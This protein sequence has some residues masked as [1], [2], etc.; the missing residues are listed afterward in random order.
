MVLRKSE[1]LIKIFRHHPLPFVLH[2]FILF[3]LL[4]P[5]YI[6]LTVLVGSINHLTLI[7]LKS[8]LVALTMLLVIYHSFIFWLDKIIITNQRVINIDWKSLFHQ[9]TNDIELHDIQS[10]AIKSHGLLEKLYFF[11]FGDIA[12]QSGSNFSVI[13]FHESHN[14]DAIEELINHLK[15]DL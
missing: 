10:I 14:P 7:I 11:N 3:L 8:S 4:A 12:I 13:M 6:L 5:F 2:I 9:E 1:K 15:S